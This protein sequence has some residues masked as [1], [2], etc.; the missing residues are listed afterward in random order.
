M[1]KIE[2]VVR[3]NGT[4]SFECDCHNITDYICPDCRQRVWLR[5]GQ[6]VNQE[7]EPLISGGE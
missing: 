2:V 4:V 3:K 1:S 5:L 6:L 7:K